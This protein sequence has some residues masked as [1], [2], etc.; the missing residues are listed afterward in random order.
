[1]KNSDATPRNVF[2][3]QTFGLSMWQT[4]TKLTIYV[5]GS[6]AFYDFVAAQKLRLIYSSANLLADSHEKLGRHIP[7]ACKWL[8]FSHY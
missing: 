3:H 2:S 5:G 4:D 8:S 6:S 7:K 1:M